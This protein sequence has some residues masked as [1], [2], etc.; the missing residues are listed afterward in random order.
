[1]SRIILLCV[2]TAFLVGVFGDDAIISWD[3]K[4]GQSSTWGDYNAQLA[5]NANSDQL[6]ARGSCS[7]TLK[8]AN[9]WW[10]VDLEFEFRITEVTIHNRATQGKRLGRFQVLVSGDGKH[11]KIA[12][13]YSGDAHDGEVIHLGMEEFRVQYVK[14]QMEKN[15]YLTLCEVTVIGEREKAKDRYTEV[16]LRTKTS[17]SGMSWNYRSHLAV[18][19][20]SDQNFNQYSCAMTNKQPNPWWQ[21]DLHH[22]YTVNRVAIYAAADV[23]GNRLAGARVDL[24]QKGKAWQNCGVIP[25]S[26]RSR[27]IHIIP[28]NFK[29]GQEVRITGKTSDPLVICEVRVYAQRAFTK[30]EIKNSEPEERSSRVPEVGILEEN[31]EEKLGRKDQ[32]ME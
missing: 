27:D 13:E 2:A 22:H 12:Q 4:A 10:A 24:R 11:W 9:N 14:I 30:K 23:S 16:A 32:I 21:T 15:D 3:K 17:M 26:A 20:T 18:A 5:V 1:M 8:A 7:H 25:N 31:P 19:G 29:V 6:L 28:C